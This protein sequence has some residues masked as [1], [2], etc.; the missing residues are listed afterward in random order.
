MPGLLAGQVD[1]GG[2]AEAEAPHPR[3]EA[4]APRAAPILIAPTLLDCARIC[5]VVSVS[6]GVFGVV[7]DRAVGDLDL[8]GDVEA[9]LRRDQPLL[10]RA[11]DGHDLER[12]AGFVVEADGAVL[13]RFGGEAAP[14]SLALTCGQLASARIAPLSR[15]HDDR[16]GVFGAEHLPPTAPSTSSVRCWMLASSVSDTLGAGHL[17]LDVRD[18]DRLADRVADDR[19]ARPACPRAGA[20]QRVLQPGRAVAFDADQAE[21]LRGERAAGVDAAHG[22]GAGRCRGSS[23]RATACACALG[24]RAREVDEAA[25]L[26]RACAA[27]A[28]GTGRAAARAAGRRC[29]GSLTRYG[30]GRDVLGGLGDGE[31]DA[32]A[33]GDRA[34]LGGHRFVGQ[35]LVA[36]GLAQSGA[37]Q[38]PR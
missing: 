16:G 29:S 28:P 36:G 22:R 4:V 3:V 31:V 15:V 20:L 5:A 37:A 10:K 1:A 18:R 14:G 17:R 24:Q 25:A 21:H 19:A 6:V 35:L 23:A 26:A 11:G 2:R 38:R 33:V 32:V 9:G 8:I 27:R 12:R 34:A 13:E 30:V 7:V